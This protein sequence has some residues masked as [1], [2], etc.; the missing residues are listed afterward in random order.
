[1]MSKTI[2]KKILISG[3]AVF[4]LCLN[5]FSSDSEKVS[6]LI[7]F[8]GANRNIEKEIS[9]TENLSALD[10]LM[11]A[12][13]IQTHPAENYVFVDEINGVENIK[14]KKVWYFTVNGEP[15]KK[16]A[17]NC[18][19]AKGDIVKWIYKKD[20]C[21]STIKTKEPCSDNFGL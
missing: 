5:A 16:L 3:I 21:S 10:A 9:Y 2:I 15:A 18:N 11:Y 7:E 6:V 13:T 14:G 12:A 8:N 20:V 1:M 4:L 17:I 19:L